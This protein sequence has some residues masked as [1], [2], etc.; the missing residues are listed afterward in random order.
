MRRPALVAL[1]LLPLLAGCGGDPAE[2]YCGAVAD[3][4]QELSDIVGSGR[5]DAL[6]DALDVFRELQGKAPDD[7]TDEWQ[8]VVGRIEALDRALE[9]AGVDPAGYDRAEPPA[10]LSAQDRASIDAAAKEL[11]SG[12]TLR[13]LQDL[14]QQARDVCH[15]PLTL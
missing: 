15:T 10:G 7:I 4:Q 9:D 6:L 13:A 11:G 5:P 12:T 1:L 2:E 8:Q 14:D 3:H